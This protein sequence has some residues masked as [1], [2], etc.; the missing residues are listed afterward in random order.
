M[1]RK[2]QFADDEYNYFV[3][4][5]KFD[6]YNGY[7]GTI[8]LIADPEEFGHGELSITD[9]GDG[10]INTAISHKYDSPGL[11]TV[12][13]RLRLNGTDGETNNDLT[14]WQLVDCLNIN[15]S[16][17]DASYFFYNC[18]EVEEFSNI[19]NWDTSNIK[20][21]KFFFGQCRK[22]KS[23]DTSNFNTRKVTN[24]S[25]MFEG[26][27]SLTELDLSFD[28]RN[29]GVM[30]RTF[31]GC[32]NLK[33]LYLSFN[34]SK[35]EAMSYMFDNCNNIGALNLSS[36]DTSNVT[37][38]PYIFRNCWKLSVLDISNWNTDKMT[39]YNAKDGVFDNCNSLS[40]NNI[41]MTNCN[42]STKSTI[43]QLYNSKTVSEN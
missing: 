34:T 30:N 18:Q 32:I 4:N 17:V 23:L 21:M 9:W 5:V 14:C 10:T 28:T 20:D 37:G 1:N 22:L 24:I 26:C 36:F 16:M 33:T 8:R 38:M 31:R 29:V 7:N 40:F 6:S 19:R 15:K 2:P 43:T 13:T 11:Y 35:V 3:F 27:R 42:D 12:K 25:G 41:R 39:S